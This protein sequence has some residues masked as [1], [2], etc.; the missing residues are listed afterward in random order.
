MTSEERKQKNTLARRVVKVMVGRQDLINEW[1]ANYGG[2]QEDMKKR[3]EWL[4][5]NEK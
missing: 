1:I 5:E 3:I 4:Q 2:D